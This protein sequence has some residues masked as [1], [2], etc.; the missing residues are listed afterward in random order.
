VRTLEGTVE[1]DPTGKKAG[2]GAYL[3]ASQECWSLAL[4]KRL[5]EHAL[6][7]TIELPD[8]AKLEAYGRS[9]PSEA[10]EPSSKPEA[11]GLA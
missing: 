6:K 11:Q 2:R 5:L 8:R 1:V 7:T 10:A 4:K 9:L 3:C